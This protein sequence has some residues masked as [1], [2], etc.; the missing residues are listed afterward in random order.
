MFFV[1]VTAKTDSILYKGS[2]NIKIVQAGL[3]L[4][5]LVSQKHIGVN[6]VNDYTDNLTLKQVTDGLSNVNFNTVDETVIEGLKIESETF[7][8]TYTRTVKLGVVPESALS[9]VVESDSTIDVTAYGVKEGDIFV[10]LKILS[11]KDGT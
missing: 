9:E 3:T 11:D 1:K 8:D 4:E 7:A 10:Q 6:K 5:T 2:A